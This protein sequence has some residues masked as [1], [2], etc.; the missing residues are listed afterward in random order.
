MSRYPQGIPASAGDWCPYCRKR[1]NTNAKT[2]RG[3]SPIF[4]SLTRAKAWAAEHAAG[5]CVL[6]YLDYY[7]GSCAYTE[8]PGAER[9]AAA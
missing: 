7:R 6:A 8:W 4:R 3:C 2:C 9:G 5:P 1:K